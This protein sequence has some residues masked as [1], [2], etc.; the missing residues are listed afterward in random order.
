VIC[1]YCSKE[2]EQ[3]VIEN[4][5]EIAWKAKRH[6]FGNAEFHKGSVVLSKHSFL[7]GSAVVSHLCRECEKVIIDYKDDKCD[8]NR[9]KS[10]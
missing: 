10:E 4:Q 5:N 6:L 9:E 2:M 7:K 8:F 3:G 1:P